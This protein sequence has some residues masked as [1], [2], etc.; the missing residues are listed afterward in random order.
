[1]ANFVGM[2]SVFLYPL[3]ESEPGNTTLG[4]GQRFLLVVLQNVQVAIRYQRMAS[5]MPEYFWYKL[6]LFMNVHG[7]VFWC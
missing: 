1:M 3:A 6:S 5:R 4:V 7:L 2:M